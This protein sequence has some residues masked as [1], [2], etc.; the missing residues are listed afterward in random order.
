MQRLFFAIGG[1]AILAISF[2]GTLFLLNSAYFQSFDSVRIEHAKLLKAA[3]EKYRIP[4]AVAA[5][6]VRLSDA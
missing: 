1:L 2:F 3:L 6:L 5:L 4:P